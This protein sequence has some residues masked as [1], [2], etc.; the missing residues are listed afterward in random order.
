M[1]SSKQ[2]KSAKTSTTP[3]TRKRP[4][5]PNAVRHSSRAESGTS[6]MSADRMIGALKKRSPW[7]QSIMHPLQGGGARIPDPCGFETATFQFVYDGT[8]AASS[9]G[10]TGV[11]ALGL[12]PSANL[13]SI[14]TLNAD[15]Y[16]FQQA[17]TDASGSDI[18]FGL[19]GTAA[20]TRGMCLTPD[21]MNT[22]ISQGLSS[23]ARVVS[24]AIHVWYEGAL[25]NTAGDYVAYNNPAGLQ[26]NGS[27]PNSF[28][29]LYGA[30]VMPITQGRAAISRWLPI[31][32]NQSA[33][34][35]GTTQSQFS[36][37]YRAFTGSDISYSPT[38]KSPMREFGVIIRGATAGTVFRYRIVA[39]IE[40]V[41]R[42]NTN[43]L[44]SVS[45][46]PI[47]VMEESFCLQNLGIEDASG[48][49]PSRAVATVPSTNRVMEAARKETSGP[50]AAITEAA[51]FVG[52]IISLA[53][54]LLALV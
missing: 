32:R 45:A 48:D 34:T 9:T 19:G 24:A 33:I 44:F 46:S 26:S 27:S 54:P 49:L 21:A 37:D 52:D 8:M 53:K 6:L 43:S 22:A 20:A 38:L 36:N 13:S 42:L 47:D 40:F 28:A 5:H 16:G 7:Y 14:V 51:G 2:P 17:A 25:L 29:A 12:Q 50:M 4:I 15:C 30:S 3:S 11:R 41:P 10:F 35:S 39:N 18:G 31:T 23:M 1:I